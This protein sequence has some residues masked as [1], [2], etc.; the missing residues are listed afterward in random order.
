M[1][2]VSGFINRYR[3]RSIRIA[4]FACAA[5]VF[6]F[7]RRQEPAGLGGWM[8]VGAWAAGTYIGVSW[9]LKALSGQVMAGAGSFLNRLRGRR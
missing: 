1:G 4:A 2:L 9:T 6:E 3:Y 5:F 7:L 8:E